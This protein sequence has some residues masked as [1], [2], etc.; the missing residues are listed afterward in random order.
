M[1]SSLWHILAPAA[2]LLVVLAVWFLL[3]AFVRS[4]SHK[5]AGE[6]VLEHMTHGCAGCTGNC[7]CHNRTENEAAA[8]QSEIHIHEH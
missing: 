2:G 3:Q 6:D 5:A 1:W 8:C 7:A 4:G